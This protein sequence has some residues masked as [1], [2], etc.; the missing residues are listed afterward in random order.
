MTPSIASFRSLSLTRKLFSSDTVLISGYVSSSIHWN[1][2]SFPLYLTTSEVEYFSISISSTST[3]FLT[4]SVNNFPVTTVSPSILTFAF[5]LVS[6]KSSRSVADNVTSSPQ[7]LILTPSR[8]GILLLPDI[9]LLTVINASDNSKELAMNFIYFSLFIIK[10][11]YYNN[12]CGFVDYF[13]RPSKR[14][15]FMRKSKIKRR[16][17]YVRHVDKRR[18]LC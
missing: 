11:N 15:C 4:N 6:M 3:S 17:L 5:I 13:L 1:S 9:A 18:V 12:R 14:D 8:M 16:F 10:I 7:A 2:D